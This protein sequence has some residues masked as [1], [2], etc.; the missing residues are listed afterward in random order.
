MKVLFITPRLPFPPFRGDNVRMFNILRRVARHHEVSLISL[1]Q[2]KEQR[3]YVSSIKPYCQEIR[4]VYKPT[5]SSLVSCGLAVFGKLPFQVAYFRSG[6]M[7]REVRKMVRE[8][9]PDVVHA[10]YIRVAQYLQE[11]PSLPRVLDLTDSFSLYLERLDQIATGLIK[12]F[13]I[14]TEYSR[15]RA[16]E[17]IIED[18]NRN[19]ICSPI[20][21]EQLLR[22]VP[23]ALIDVLYNGVDL[24]LF[25]RDGAT[26][27]EEQ[28]VIF[29]GNMSY[30]PNADAAVYFVKEILPRIRKVLPAVRVFLVGQRPSKE[31]QQLAS[32]NV[33]VTGLVPDIAVEYMKSSVAVAPTRWGS[34]TLTKVIEPLAMGVPVVATSVGVAGLGLRDGREILIADDPEVFA[35]KVIAVLTDP[36][37]GKRLAEAGAAYVRTKFSWDVLAAQLETVYAEVT[38]K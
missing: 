16:Y 26:A 15:L 23:R 19:T 8:W 25:T 37:L 5:I 2:R 9:Q 14:K 28:R 10:H 17:S 30:I 13:L 18:F 36:A 21:R 35:Q 24:D 1:I 32:E 4:I 20:D 3:E 31:V 38:A 27:P 34:G 22:Q 33:T 7:R 29:A 11:A 6:A 12:K